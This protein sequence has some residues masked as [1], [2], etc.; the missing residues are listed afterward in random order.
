MF[1]KIAIKGKI[2][3]ADIDTIVLRN[4]LEQCTK[5]DELYYTSTAYANFEGCFITLSGDMVKCKCSVNKLWQKANT[6]K[7]DNSRPMTFRN[8]VKTIYDLLLRLCLKP[9]N[10]IVTYYEIGLTMKLSEPATEYISRVEDIGG[11]QLWNDANYPENRQKTTER[12]KYYRKILKI[13]DK[14]FEA[15]EKGRNVG[16]NIVRIETI[17]RHQSVRLL[18]LIDDFNLMKLAK[19]FYDDWTSIRFV[20]EL[21]GTPGIKMCQL[22]KAREIHRLGVERYKDK[23]R[24][25][26]L[27]KKITKKQW[28]TIRNFARSW[29][30]ERKRYIEELTTYEREYMDILL[31]GFQIGSINFSKRKNITR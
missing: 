10:T 31:S 5:G 28:E 3:T 30:D 9:E 24:A 22:D 25:M 1:D 29:P 8:A 19:I 14:T 20:R 27:E 11:K 13:Y 26:Y 16:Q 12:S 15:A 21:S 18:D 4:Y 7:L 6:G 2:D 23:Y 17:Y